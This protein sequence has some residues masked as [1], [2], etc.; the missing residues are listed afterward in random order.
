MYDR[1]IFSTYLAARVWDNVMTKHPARLD[2][3]NDFY[4]VLIGQVEHAELDS[5]IE[6]GKTYE[7]VLEE[8]GPVPR[9]EKIPYFQTAQDLALVMLNH[10]SHGAFLA[11]DKEVIDQL[12]AGDIRKTIDGYIDEV[13]R[14]YVDNEAIYL[15]FPQ[16]TAG[17][18]YLDNLRQE[19]EA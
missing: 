10:L 2:E 16:V 1:N 8:E 4:R 19:L 17:L 12:Y 11:V 5:E 6:K 13:R 14:G 15:R 3:I 18:N 7:Q 9:I